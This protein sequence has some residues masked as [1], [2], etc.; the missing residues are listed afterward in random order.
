MNSQKITRRTMLKGMGVAMGLPLLE[1]MAPMRLLAASGQGALASKPKFPVRMAV[2]YM[3]NGVNPNTWTPTGTGSE[4]ELAPALEPLSSFKKDI[5]VLT[6]LWNAA[7]NTGDGHYVKTG[8]FLT[9]T[10]ITRTTGSNLCSGGVSMDQIAARRIGNMTLLPS[11][12]LGIEPVTTGVD[13]N[14]GFTRLYGSHIA[15]STPTSPLAKEINPRFA[16]DRLFRSTSRRGGENSGNEKSVLDAVL[17]D[18]K[19]LRSKVGVSDQRKLDEYFESVRSVERRIEFDARRTAGEY[20]SDPLVQK[21]IDKLGGRIDDYYK[22]PARASERRGNHTE[23]VRLMMDIMVLAFWTDSTRIST[24]MF[25]NAVSGHSFSFVEGVKGSHHEISHHEKT[26]EKLEQYKRINA[27]HVQQYAYMLERMRSIKEGE[28]TLLDN[29]MVLLGAGMR[30]GNAHDPHN[31]PL[32]L[33]GRGGGTLATG[34]HLVFPKKTPL[35]NLYR[36]MLTRIGAPVDQFADSTGELQGL[37][38][39]AFKGVAT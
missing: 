35:C 31:L 9:G 3:A 10:T 29:S 11:L 32:V 25:G 7:T 2:L 33:A 15:W 38:D 21:E 22:D 19:R 34:R 36:S 28:G 17:A 4:F 27:W 26:A 39:P 1:S 13:T 16:F 20:Q 18:A 5:L 24:F 37:A 12:E 30:D 8:G 23:H 6:E 14:V